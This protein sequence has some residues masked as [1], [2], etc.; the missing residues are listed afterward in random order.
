ML[1]AK[2]IAA[3]LAAMKSQ[4]PVPAGGGDTGRSD[5][6]PRKRKSRFSDAPAEIAP[7]QPSVGKFQW[8]SGR[9]APAGYERKIFFPLDKHPGIFF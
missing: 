7:Q 4:A 2:E 5:A 1:K 6:A 8:G 9:N 3:K